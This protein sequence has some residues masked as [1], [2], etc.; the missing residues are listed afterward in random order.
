M[1]LLQTLLCMCPV[2]GLL[3]LRF[4][5]SLAWPALVNFP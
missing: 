4:L 1:A 2:L 3:Q 5:R